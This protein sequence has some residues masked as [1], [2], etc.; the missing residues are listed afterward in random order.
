MG[1]F[2]YLPDPYV[3]SRT[4][5]IGIVTPEPPSSLSGNEVTAQRWAKLL[6]ELG[7][8]VAVQAAYA[9]EDYDLLISLHAMKSAAA[10]EAFH[11]RFPERPQ[12]LALAGTDLYGDLERDPAALRSLELADRYVVLQP[13][14]L[15]RLP[16]ELRGRAVAIHQSLAPIAPSAPR[17]DG[18]FDVCVLSHLRPVKDPLLV[19]AAVRRLPSDSVVRVTHVGAAL[20][21]ELGRNAE[22]ETAISTRYRWVDELDRAAALGVLAASKM[23]VLTSRLEGGANVV[24]E[25]IAAGVPVLSTRIDG[26]VGILGEDYPGYFPVGDAQALADLLR[27]AETD[28]EFYADLRQRIERLA[29]LVDPAREREAWKRLL[30]SLR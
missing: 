13:R 17:H 28:P 30:A 26:S 4:L 7:H 1:R 11:E 29:P 10:I 8:R 23:L 27:N 16:Q 6:G 19:A 2:P 20:E 3:T 12:I 14:G 22:E 25:A 5:S 24:S 15:D 18:S 21:P 9:G